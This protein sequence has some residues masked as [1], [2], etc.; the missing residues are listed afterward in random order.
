MINCSPSAYGK[1]PNSLE[2]VCVRPGSFSAERLHR[3]LRPATRCILALLAIFSGISK[4]VSTGLAT[5]MPPRAGAGASG[6]GGAEEELG[7]LDFL[8]AVIRPTTSVSAY[9]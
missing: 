8:S 6:S 3:I 2:D 4:R 7:I 9:P 1:E 5:P